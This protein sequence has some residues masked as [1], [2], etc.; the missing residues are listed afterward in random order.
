MHLNGSSLAHQGHTPNSQPLEYRSAPNAT[1]TGRELNDLMKCWRWSYKCTSS[2]YSKKGQ[3]GQAGDLDQTRT[4]WTYMYTVQSHVKP[5]P[6]PPTQ[7]T[8]GPKHGRSKPSASDSKTENT[9]SVCLS[10]AP[11]TLRSSRLK[12]FVHLLFALH[13]CSPH[14]CKSIVVG[15]SD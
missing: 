6:P 2:H 9:Q 12:P 15:M 3:A 4:V 10:K 7:G 11:E 14:L 8:K 13:V 1:P 5:M